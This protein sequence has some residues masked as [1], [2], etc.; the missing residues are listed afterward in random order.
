MRALR[1]VLTLLVAVLVLAACTDPPGASGTAESGA[2]GGQVA[3]GGAVGAEAADD[4]GGGA[5]DGRDVVTT[6]AGGLLVGL[7]VLLPWLVLVALLAAVAWPLWRR[8]RRR[9]AA[10]AGTA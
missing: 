4:A 1:A 6:L 8:R 7:G 2:G 9:A 5:E 3:D 10:E